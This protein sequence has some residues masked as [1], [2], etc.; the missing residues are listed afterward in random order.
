M[1]CKRIS[2][3]KRQD[4]VSLMPILLR[5]FISAKQLYIKNIG[6]GEFQN[7]RYLKIIHRHEVSD[8][9]F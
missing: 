3:K 7:F 1:I 5:N 9:I 2:R 6:Q 8:F 4:M